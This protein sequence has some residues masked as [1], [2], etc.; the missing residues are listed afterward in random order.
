MIDTF[1]EARSFIDKYYPNLRAINKTTKIGLLAKF[2]AELLKKQT[3]V[4]EFA[5]G[6]VIACCSNCKFWKQNTFY[7]Y[8]DAENFGFC[9]ELKTEIEIE[10]NAGW[11]GGVVKHIETKNKFSCALHNKL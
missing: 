4:N 3:K 8:K 2:G 6:D 7:D 5:L 11:G 10:I 9:S 1:E